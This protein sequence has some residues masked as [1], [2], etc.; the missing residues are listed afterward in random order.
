M[1]I[2]SFLNQHKWMS[3]CALPHAFVFVDHHCA[4][5]LQFGPELTQE[6]KVNAQQ[7]RPET[8]L[9]I[10]GY[11]PLDQELSATSCEQA[12]KPS[13]RWPTRQVCLGAAPFNRPAQVSYF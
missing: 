12:M 4:K 8:A 3:I 1:R 7:H 11:A 5:I 10:E 9:R 2:S 13:V 6:R